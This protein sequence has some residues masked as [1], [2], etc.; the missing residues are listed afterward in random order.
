MVS[1]DGL[2]N[3]SSRSTE[4]EYMMEPLEASAKYVQC[5]VKNDILTGADQTLCY[6]LKAD[7]SFM[8]N[9]PELSP[10]RCLPYNSERGFSRP[11]KS[12]FTSIQTMK[13]RQLLKKCPR[14][15]KRALC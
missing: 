13:Y 9:H 10:P 1:S 4:T 11:E 5:C 6:V 3:T 8:S 12:S 7:S 2:L 15:T 14:L